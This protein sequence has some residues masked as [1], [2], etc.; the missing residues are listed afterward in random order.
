MPAPSVI[1][2]EA[3][4]LYI[5]VFNGPDEGNKER[6]L[7]AEAANPVPCSLGPV[8]SNLEMA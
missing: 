4:D 8:P 6:I 2:S 5:R 7:L 3:K 1:L